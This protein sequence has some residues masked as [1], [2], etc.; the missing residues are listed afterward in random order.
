MRAASGFARQV[1]L[2]KAG[3]EPEI[4]LRDPHPPDSVAFG[5]FKHYGKDHR[6]DVHVKMTVHMGQFEP[7]SVKSL[8]L[9]RKLSCQL[10]SG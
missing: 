1:L 6:V 4:I 9:G 5:K 7:G 10:L 2:M 3:G 8:E